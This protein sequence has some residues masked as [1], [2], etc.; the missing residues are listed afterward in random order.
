MEVDR[1]FL[2]C[3]RSRGGLENSILRRVGHV[4]QSLFG[5]HFDPKM[6]DR[7]NSILRLCAFGS[8][9]VSVAALLEN[10]PA[11]TPFVENKRFAAKQQVDAA[12]R[13]TRAA[14]CGNVARMTRRYSMAASFAL[15]LALSGC[16]GITPPVTGNPH[17]LATPTPAAI[18]ISGDQVF[19]PH[20]GDVWTFK[21]G[22]GDV[23]TITL[24]A[25]PASNLVP[26]GSISL[27]Y[28]K[29]SCRAY[30]GAGICDALLHFVLSP[31]PDGSWASMASLFYF[32]TQVPDYM[33][34]HHMGTSDT[35]QVP[36]MPMPY[37][38]VPASATTGITNSGPTM[39]D[40]WDA[41]DVLSF[42]SIISGSAAARVRWQTDSYIENVSTP[43][44][45][46]PALVSEQFESTCIHE[47]W[48]FAPGHGL[49]KVIPL[50]NGSCTAT[51]PLL[52]MERIN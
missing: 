26:A 18:T 2:T 38:I 51:D 44:Y 1:D 19:A 27:V 45:E 23:T 9:G 6:C 31:Q 34:G 41:T 42:D 15:L 35:I 52:A 11:P 21:N 4:L 20:V 32:P 5:L 16:G 47:K 30:W 7:K 29:N 10:R 13:H 22:Y 8:G 40:R 49:V 12:R 37:T 3:D 14:G 17:P 33:S 50:D 28:Q 25:V 48:Y 46:G 36:G 39:Y 24:E 43:I